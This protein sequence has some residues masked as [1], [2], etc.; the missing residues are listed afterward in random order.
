MFLVR[1]TIGDK[2]RE[3]TLDRARLIQCGD[4]QATV[5]TDDWLSRLRILEN[6]FTVVKSPPA[7]EHAAGQIEPFFELNYD[8]SRHTVTLHLQPMCGTTMYYYISSRGDFVCSTHISLLRQAGVPIEENVEA[9]PEF[10]VYRFVMPPQTLYKDIFSLPFG[11]H[12]TFEMAR[13]G[14]RLIRNE[15]YSPPIR[16]VERI[17]DPRSAAETT[18]QYL[19]EA[20]TQLRSFGDSVSLLFSGGLDS[21]LLYRLLQTALRVEETCSTSFSFACADNDAEREYALSA[22][23]ALG[24][25]HRFY[26]VE[27]DEYLYGFLEAVAAAE[28]PLH[29][30]QSVLLYVLSR[31]MSQQGKKL[32]V[33]G[34]GADTFFGLH[35][36]EQV[37]RP[38]KRRDRVLSMGPARKV[39]DLLHPFTHRG[40][41]YLSYG[42]PH[43]IVWELGA[44]GRWDWISR[45][46]GASRGM[47]V[48]SRRGVL[49]NFAAVPLLDAISILSICGDLM[50]ARHL[51]SKLAESQGLML[52]YPF[53]SSALINHSFHID[54]D[55]KL[56]EPK[57]ILRAVA[58]MLDLPEFIIT[59]E[60]QS[61][62]LEAP[63][64]AGRDGLFQPLLPMVEQVVDPAWITQVDSTRHGEAMTLWNI[65]N[66]AIWK[67]LCIQ[68]E[69]LNDLKG[70]L[71]ENLGG[72]TCASE[73]HA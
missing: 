3:V 28:E 17:W 13:D 33:C 73:G 2:K 54:W 20:V 37:Y 40:A 9:L 45:N 64:W 22:A 69:S 18:L 19:S 66:Y 4:V 42:N 24:V 60:K 25:Q 46:L 56:R 26:P 38:G 35:F 30:L 52:Y 39:L 16:S 63:Y 48:A 59:R 6:G 67:K 21:S 55:T 43:S 31:K 62:G 15:T 10:F 8:D 47:A 44:Y 7:N 49:R 72:P 71:S 11:A 57:N 1:L 36:H 14:C 34:Y 58:R 65:V 53:C 29:H 12:L 32:V 51:W 50:M 61:F 41:R 70:Q 23:E 68:G 5:V 27:R